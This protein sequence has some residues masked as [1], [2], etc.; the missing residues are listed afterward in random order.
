MVIAFVQWFDG[1]KWWLKVARYKVK[2]DVASLCR[3]SREPSKQTVCNIIYVAKEF[4]LLE[5]YAAQE[6]S[7]SHWACA[8]LGPSEYK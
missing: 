5:L 3:V 1:Y 2:R 8:K 4:G 7:H 6:I